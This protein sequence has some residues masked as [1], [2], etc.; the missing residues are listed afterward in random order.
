VHGKL[1]DKNIRFSAALKT[2]GIQILST[3]VGYW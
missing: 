1:K 2:G 3:G